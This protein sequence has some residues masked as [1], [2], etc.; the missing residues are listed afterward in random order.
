MVTQLKLSNI[1]VKKKMNDIPKLIYLMGAGRSGTTALAT[2]L[3]GSPEVQVLG[4]M[5]QFYEHLHQGKKCS[6]GT[7]IDQ[8][9]FW[10][11]VLERLPDEVLSNVDRKMEVERTIERHQAII[12]HVLKGRDIEELNSY[13]LSWRE[14][15]NVCR[16]VSRK[17]VMLDSAK[18]IGRALA[19]KHLEGI[20]LKVI[21]MVRDVRGVVH[22][23]SKNVQTPR[24]PLSAIFYYLVINS[25]AEIIRL[26]FLK[27]KCL[28]VRY[29]D[30]MEC[31]DK[32]FTELANFLQM[33]L[34]CV[35]QKIRTDQEFDIG[36]IVGGNRIREQ[37]K[38]KFRKDVGWQSKM[39]AWRKV[40]LYIGALPLM[41]CNRYSV[42]G[43]EGNK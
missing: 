32:F 43:K 7:R 4:E 2:F 21:Y 26:F 30:M 5:H 24:R 13:L 11:K 10:R 29:E 28:K 39:T 23:F 40:L 20:D 6:C 19:L 38:V 42:L 27:Q 16:E 9:E 37:R 35:K 18:Y 31:P 34:D 3:G 33:D 17:D 36:H 25:I 15:F 8:C 14:I 12:N 22:S 41:L 1:E